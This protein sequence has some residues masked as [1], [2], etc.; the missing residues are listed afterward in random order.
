MSIPYLLRWPLAA[1]L[2]LAASLAGCTHIEGPSRV[3]QRA[4]ARLTQML[5][6]RVAGEPRSCIAAFDLG[7][8]QI[9]DR[10]AVVYDSGDTIWVSRPS[11]PDA[12]DT[13]DIVVIE[14]TGGQL[15]KT[16]LVRTVD[17]VNRFTTGVVFLGDFVP[18]RKP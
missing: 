16:D 15:C 6:G 10:T 4:E 12:L 11:D 18:Y 2:G 3:Q 17:R 8:L 1:G 13:R 5:E 7:R 9:L 14:R